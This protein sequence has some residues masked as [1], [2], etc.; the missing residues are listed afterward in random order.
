VGYDDIIVQQLLPSLRPLSRDLPQ[1]YP[2]LVRDWMRAL[3]DVVD[4]LMSFLYWPTKATMT[5]QRFVSVQDPWS[6]VTDSVHIPM[7][8]HVLNH[9]FSGEN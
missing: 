4:C 2:K 7:S 6:G 1:G 3:Y 9:Q 5:P 8:S